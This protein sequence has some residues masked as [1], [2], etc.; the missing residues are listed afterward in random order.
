[1]TALMLDSLK[2][3]DDVRLNFS[4]EGT[5]L[6]NVVLGFLMFGV[7]L[8]IKIEN[9]KSLLHKPK[10]VIIGLLC[11]FF[12][13]P[14][15]TFFFVW[16]IKPTP[17]VALGM[18]LVSCCPGGNISNF[19]SALSKANVALAVSLTAIG[20]IL[21]VVLTPANFAMWGG[22]YNEAADIY[23]PIQIDVWQMF[24]TVFI[25]LGI[26]LIVGMF[27]SNKF[28]SFT[29]KII[30]P[31]KTISLLV[32]IAF[33]GFAFKSNY[34]YF[35]K[36]IQYIFI[37]VLIQ[38]TI[39]L[40]IGYVAGKSFRLSKIDTRTLTIESGIHNSGLALVL[41]FNPKLFDGLGGMAFIAAWW[42]IW[43]LIS[44]FAIAYY[45]SKRPITA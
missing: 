18:I 39:A 37:L 43:H 4:A 17:S 45:W 1:M 32:F 11:Q 9:F 13:L 38:N 5:H 12:F 23:K 20:T 24:Q 26:P 30:K 21:A 10:A 31:I 34:D 27:I 36:Y 7:A 22:L 16:L 41:I 33:V 25:I 6:L 29:K 15:L 40:G 35:V 8:E 19:I 3:L 14:M 2:I 44:G 28:P 42:G